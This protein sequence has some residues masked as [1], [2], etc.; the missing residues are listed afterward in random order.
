MIIKITRDEYDMLFSVKR[1]LL[2]IT[3]NRWSSGIN[4]RLIDQFDK[5]FNNG[6][7]KAFNVDVNGQNVIKDFNITTVPTI[8]S[9]ENGKEI[10]RLIDEDTINK[11]IIN[12]IKTK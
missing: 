7:I 12:K 2:V 5:S 8:I 10:G 3:D 6:N 11:L 9:F 1:A 4:K